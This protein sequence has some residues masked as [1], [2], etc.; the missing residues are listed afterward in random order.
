VDTVM[1]Y[2]YTP[3]HRVR[4]SIRRSLTAIEEME[5]DNTMMYWHLA[6]VFMS[7]VFEDCKRKGLTPRCAMDDVMLTDL[8]A[9]AEKQLGIYV[10]IEE[11]ALMNKFQ[12]LTMSDEIDRRRAFAFSSLI[13]MTSSRAQR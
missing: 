8:I 3:M 7:K 2:M 10:S 1:A 5:L 13:R 6:S 12:R 9:E 4:L 11:L